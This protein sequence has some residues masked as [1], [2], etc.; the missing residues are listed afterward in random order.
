MEEETLSVFGG[1]FLLTRL[2]VREFLVERHVA[3]GNVHTAVFSVQ[4]EVVII[5]VLFISVE[6]QGERIAAS[7]SLQFQ[8]ARNVHKQS[9]LAERYQSEITFGDPRFFRIVPNQINIR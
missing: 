5:P 2:E 9:L 6:L 1:F 7:A 8:F 3:G 4:L